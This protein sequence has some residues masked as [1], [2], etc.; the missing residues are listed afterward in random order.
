MTEPAKKHGAV[1]SWGED[2]HALRLYRSLQVVLGPIARFLFRTRRSGIRKI[3]KRGP[4]ILVTNHASNLDPVLVVLS[5]R[6]PVF[7]LGKR[8][9][10]TTRF[11]SWFFQTLGGQIPVDRERG[12]NDPAIDAAVRALERGMAI[13]IYPEAHR[14]PDGRLQ[15]GKFGVGRLAYLT[16]APCYPV[17]VDGT[18]EVWPK[19]KRL[20]RPFRRTRILV[21]EPRRYARDAARAQDREACQRVADDLMGDLAKLLGQDYDP[22]T[23]PIARSRRGEAAKPEALRETPE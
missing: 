13:G 1:H 23:A 17:A 8:E 2:R 14:S 6:R 5:M 9:L 16:G 12:G 22:A 3:P 21:G 11:R 10:F 20:P 7:H 15:R 18:F 4:V 19:T